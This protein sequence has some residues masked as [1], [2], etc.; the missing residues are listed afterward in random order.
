MKPLA[1][2]KVPAAPAESTPERT[3]VEAQAMSTVVAHT[4]DELLTKQELAAR[5][6]KT[7]RC[8]E[9]WMRRG[10]LPYIKIAHTVR[11]KWHDVLQALERFT[12]R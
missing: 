3:H 1:F 2:P 7:P 9:Q 11:F 5:L 10:Y 12:I 4:G 6:K 8:I